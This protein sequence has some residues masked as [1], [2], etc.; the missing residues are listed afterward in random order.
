MALPQLQSNKLASKWLITKKL[1]SSMADNKGGIVK[2]H[3]EEGL[4]MAVSILEE[5]GSGASPSWRCERSC[6]LLGVLGTFGSTKR[7]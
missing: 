4:K 3:H 7:R 1:G 6:V 5:F 2:K